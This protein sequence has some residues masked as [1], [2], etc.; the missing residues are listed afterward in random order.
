MNR[1][2][3]IF[4]LLGLLL[5]TLALSACGGA[6]QETS[7]PTGKF[8]KEGESNYGLIFRDDGTFSVFIEGDVI[9]VNGTYTAEGSTFTETG[10]DG[11]CKSPMEFKYTFD[12]S[13]LTFNYAGNPDDDRDC[14]G[15]HA[16]FN[17]VT[18]TLSK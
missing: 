9:V 15:R 3:L 8:I 17:G 16:D 13:E 4:L 18:Y 14:S 12:G 2:R 7:F 6:S 10:N 11:G 5:V 1:N